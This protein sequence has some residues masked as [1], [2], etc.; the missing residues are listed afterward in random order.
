MF[1]GSRQVSHLWFGFE[2]GKFPLKTSNFFPLGK[3]NLFGSGQK[4]PGSKAGW[5]LIYCRSKVSSGWVRQG[6]TLQKTL[7]TAVPLAA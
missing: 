5:P 7:K 2:F 4:V 6:L 1:C 3:K